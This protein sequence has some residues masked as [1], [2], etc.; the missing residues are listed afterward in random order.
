MGK[1]I[2]MTCLV[3]NCSITN[4]EKPCYT[5]DEKNALNEP[6]F[7]AMALLKPPIALPVDSLKLDGINPNPT[8]S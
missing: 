7:N 5:L 4:L 1:P 2:K 6:C 3:I 8:M